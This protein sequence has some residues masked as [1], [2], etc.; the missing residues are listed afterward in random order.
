M[1]PDFSVFLSLLNNI[2]IFIVLIAGYAYFSTSRVRN[3]DPRLK[4]VLFGVFCGL[5]TIGAMHI[6]IPIAEGVRV[7]QRNA[8]ITLAGAFG[9][10][11]TAFVSA[12]LAAIYRVYLGGAGALAGI[13]AAFL[14]AF[15]GVFLYRMRDGDDSALKIALGAILATIVIF[16]SF[17][18]IVD[19][20]TGWSILKRMFVPWGSAMFIGM[21]FGGLM[22]AREDLRVK[23]ES[24][25][26]RSEARFKNLFESSEI[27]IWNVDFLAVFRELK[28]LR[29]EGV[30]DFR[31]HVQENRH[32]VPDLVRMISIN[33]VN[34]A[35]LKLFKFNNE[36]DLKS[37]VGNLFG[38]SLHEFCMN[39]FCAVWEDEKHY[40]AEALMQTSDGEELTVII[41]LP[42]P[43]T[44]ELVQNTPIGIL[45]ISDRKQAEQ[46]RDLALQD[47]ERANE[48]KSEFLATMSHELRT[49]LNAILGFSDIISKQ[50]FGP[51]DE[52]GRYVEYAK[53][54]H[55]SGELLLDLVN[56]LLDISTIEAGSKS[57]KLAQVEVK[58]LIS[59][60]LKIVE[61]KAKLNGVDLLSDIP[62]DIPPLYADRRALLQVLLNLL[63]NAIK[64]TSS[65]GSITVSVN[66]SLSETGIVIRDTGRGIPAENLQDVMNPFVRTESDPHKTQEGWGLGLAIAKSL[67]E[68]HEGRLELE[69][70]VGEGTIVHIR[71]PTPAS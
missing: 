68:L 9:G 14:S 60:S 17:L 66:V 36:D 59:E 49:P 64:F 22:L 12:T 10:P 37:S 23:V 53:D 25:I 57:L 55:L 27:S 1:V 2:S 13:V 63:S 71:F 69:S 40:R 5:V 48:A 33:N 43:D 42:L 52:N 41:F 16:P 30:K 62:D 61:Q 4:N 39:V 11:V 28:R 67:I 15:A 26:T 8:I 58:G 31:Q 50:Y 34:P 44:E 32:L 20:E 29:K 47:A 21:F 24:E 7:D 18:L 51:A 3:L 54:I 65:G 35:S 6:F 56:D 38:Q 19:F 46:S 70:K 45:D